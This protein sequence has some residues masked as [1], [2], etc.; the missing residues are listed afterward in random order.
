MNKS[1]IHRNNIYN[2]IS[3]F[4]EKEF[5]TH[6]DRNNAYKIWVEEPQGKIPLGKLDVG[7]WVILKWFLD[8]EDG[9]VWT[10]FN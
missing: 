7:G 9:V 2:I 10:G 3:Y 5:R 8:R 1:E 4:I 6:G